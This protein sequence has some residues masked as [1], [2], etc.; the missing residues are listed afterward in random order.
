MLVD[1]FVVDS[2]AF[3]FIDNHTTERSALGGSLALTPGSHTLYLQATR[4]SLLPATGLFDYFDNVTVSAVTAVPEP[5]SL[6]LL[7]TGFITASRAVRRKL[8]G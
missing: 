6:L 2:Y 8:N 3:N 5:A 1:G 7:G 4:G